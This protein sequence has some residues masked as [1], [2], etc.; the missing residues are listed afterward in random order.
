MPGKWHSRYSPVST[1]RGG[2]TGLAYLTGWRGAGG[3]SPGKRLRR[4]PEARYSAG[5][6]GASGTGGAGNR[7]CGVGPPQ[8]HRRWTRRVNEFSDIS[9]RTLVPSSSPTVT[10]MRSGESAE[11]GAFLAKGVTSG[12][13]LPWCRGVPGNAL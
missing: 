2:G 13:T 9:A 3:A 5:G 8:S 6:A 7:G 11:A 4:W 1:L 12:G 10:R